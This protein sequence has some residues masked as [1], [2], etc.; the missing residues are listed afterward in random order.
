MLDSKL[1]IEVVLFA[2]YFGRSS[3]WNQER[4]RE[5]YQFC[6][7]IDT[8]FDIRSFCGN[9]YLFRYGS[10]LHSCCLVERM[11][12]I[13]VSLSTRFDEYLLQAECFF[14]SHHSWKEITV[15][16]FKYFEFHWR[17]IILMYHDDVTIQIHSPMSPYSG[18]I[19]T[20]ECSYKG[21]FSWLNQYLETI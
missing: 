4:S 14:Y 9:V 1:G 15:D 10:L 17:E 13:R 12:W 3:E 19:C 21:F 16:D 8:F 7:A 18:R 5:W 6:L 11:F 2:A 20:V